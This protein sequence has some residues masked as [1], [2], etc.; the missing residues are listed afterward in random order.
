MADENQVYTQHAYMRPMGVAL[1]VIG[2]D[3]ELGP[4]LFKVPTAPARALP[5]MPHASSAFFRA[6]SASGQASVTAA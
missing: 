6:P 1:T 5:R 3:E 4:Q 2:I